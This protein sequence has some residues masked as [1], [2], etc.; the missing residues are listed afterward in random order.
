M[1]SQGITDLNDLIR[2]MKPSLHPE[3]FVFGHIPTK[4]EADSQNVLK[5]LTGLPVQM[6]F[7]ED[8]GWT[9]IIE[10]SVAESIQLQ[11]TFP[12]KKITLNIHSSL[13]A[14]GFM[15]A[16]LKELTELNIGC[17]LVSGYFHDHLFIPA[18]KEE[19]VMEVLQRMATEA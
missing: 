5:L 17:N 13:D 1:T 7:R 12:C 3:V 8:E 10:Q 14:V 11:S 18:G 2:S 16:I 19:A 15:A 6:M 4:T 9:V